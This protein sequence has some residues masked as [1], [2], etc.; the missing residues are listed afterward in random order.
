MLDLSIVVINH[1]H[2]GIIE[3]C[4]ES[5]VA[6]PDKVSIEVLVIDN[7]PADGLTEW[8]DGRFHGVS[9]RANRVPMG[10]AANAN[11]GLRTAVCGR[12]AM[13]LNPDVIC[14]PG[15]LE[16]LVAYMDSHPL[17]GV[18]GPKLLNAGGSLQPSC[19][20]FPTPLTL[21]ARFLRLE[22]VFRGRMEQYLMTDWDHTA[23]SEVDWVTGA[24]MI[25]R[26]EAIA[27]VGELDDSYFMYWE[28]L[29]LCLRLWHG[30]WRVGYV[31]EAHAEHA[32]LRQ[33]VKEPFSHFARWQIASALKLF[34]KFGWALS[35][36]RR[37][38]ESLRD[39]E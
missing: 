2:R 8:L 25:L 22:N 34:W 12:Y 1:H 20:R 5:L 36:E 3:K 6:L 4:I 18:A 24:I 33:G 38:G 23:E 26:R 10:Y 7:T 37:P 14:F 16:N 31:P 28:D 27:A 13:M 29:D 17:A 11:L 30:G 21:G 39:R 19:R 35:R 15:L 32:H 9:A